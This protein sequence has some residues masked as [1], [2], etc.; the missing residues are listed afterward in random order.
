MKKTM[1]KSWKAVEYSDLFLTFQ[2]KSKLI[3]YSE[4]LTVYALGIIRVKL[5]YKD[6]K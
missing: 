2:L 5:I 3:H 4:V 6:G 1:L